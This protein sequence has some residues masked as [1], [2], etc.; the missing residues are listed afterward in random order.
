MKLMITW[1]VHPSERAEVMAVFAGMDLADYQSQQGP[2]IKILDRW[3]DLLN[4]RGFGVCETDDPQALSA[5]LM[6]WH[7]AV[8]FE[9]FVVHDDAEAHEIVKGQYG[10]EG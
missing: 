1:E 5:W 6:N 2:T 10:S 7:S 4:A 3:H 8:D 9:V